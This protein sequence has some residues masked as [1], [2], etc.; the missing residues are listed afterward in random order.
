M[1][2]TDQNWQTE[3]D[4]CG[5]VANS[6]GV[7]LFGENTLGFGFKVSATN[8]HYVSHDQAIAYYLKVFGHYDGHAFKILNE[9]EPFQFTFDK[10]IWPNLNVKEVR[11]DV[12]F[13]RERLLASITGA[14]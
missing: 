3:L 4:H 2:T 12:K 6:K 11:D 5:Q 14:G 9:R 7:I 8:T 1:A 13:L 10:E